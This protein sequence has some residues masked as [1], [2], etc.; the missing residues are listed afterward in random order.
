[1]ER[2]REV[3]AQFVE[4]ELG[5]RDLLVV[6][7]PL[8]SL[9]AIRLTSD[10]DAAQKVIA[11]LEGRRDDLTPREGYERNSMVGSPQRIQTLRTQIAIS[12]LNALAVQLGTLN[13]LRK[14]LIVVSERLDHAP[15]GRGQERL[16][17]VEGLVRVREPRARV[18][19]PDRSA[20]AIR[21]GGRTRSGPDAGGAGYGRA[22]DRP[23]ARA[24]T[25]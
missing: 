15:R 22:D 11:T 2:A 3:I 18:D 24:L 10:R 12:A 14:T 13:N 20:V 16:A 1:M 5:P 25:G 4:R 8:D 17:T 9:L 6:M 7:K 21:G 19:L 23:C